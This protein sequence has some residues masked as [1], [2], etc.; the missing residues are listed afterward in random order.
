MLFKK[1]KKQNK[2]IQKKMSNEFHAERKLK[3][4][5]FFFCNNPDESLNTVRNVFNIF[6]LMTQ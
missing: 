1:K 6:N 3:E 2:Q 5:V 4:N